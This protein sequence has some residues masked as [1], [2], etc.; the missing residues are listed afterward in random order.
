MARQM[1]MR[2][3]LALRHVVRGSAYCWLFFFKS[4]HAPRPCWLTDQH[5]L[6]SNSLKPSL[7]SATELILPTVSFA[8][9]WIVP[10]TKNK[11]GP[12]R[13]SWCSKRGI[14]TGEQSRLE[15]DAE[16]HRS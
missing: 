10:A 3:R 1:S 2:L 14:S 13:F 6:R 8:E 12:P 7:W 9:A 11:T 4:G 16:F 15:L 5:G